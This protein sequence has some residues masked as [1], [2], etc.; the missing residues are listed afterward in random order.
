M[1]GLD[2]SNHQAGINF[3]EFKDVKFLIL[4][5]SYTGWGTGESLHKDKSFETFYK[6][7]KEKGIP[8]GVYH[9]SCANT[10][11]KGIKEAEFL[12][13][14]CLEGKRFEFP[15]YI[16]V[17]DNRHQTSSK[18][19]VTSAIQGF[20]E[21]LELK[22]YYVGIYMNPNFIK[23]YVEIEDLRA[24]DKWLASW[25]DK[26]PNYPIT[27]EVYGLWQYTSSDVESNTKVDANYCYKDYPSIIKYAGLNGY[28]KET[29]EET[30]T[31]EHYIVKKGD[32]LYKIA[33]LYN[34][35]IMYIYTQ[36]KELID[37]ENIKRGIDVNLMWIYPN[38]EIII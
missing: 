30:E 9:Y 15:I 11:E 18:K 32:T 1:R 13:N 35:S 6:Q 24:Y 31:I 26:L 4:R 20:C 37:N 25:T 22:G 36:N 21:Y 33:E 27:N 19:Y 38:Q 3:D 34:T 10:Y 12:Y 8:V 7:A 2:I 16:D 29:I 23:N 28:E 14:N 5:G 17:E